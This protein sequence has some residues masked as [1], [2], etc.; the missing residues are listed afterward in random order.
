M[1]SFG[2][3]GLRFD[4]SLWFLRESKEERITVTTV[5]QS[6]WSGSLVQSAMWHAAFPGGLRYWWPSCRQPARLFIEYS[7]PTG[8]RVLLVAMANVMIAMVENRIEARHQWKIATKP[9]VQI[10][11][12]P[13]WIVVRTWKGMG[14]FD[15]PKPCRRQRIFP[16]H[17]CFQII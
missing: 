6:F 11:H 14:N 9:L 16:T 13:F 12:V 10:H 8:E 7:L 4:R 17:T 2:F 15:T 3:F 1:V 5:T